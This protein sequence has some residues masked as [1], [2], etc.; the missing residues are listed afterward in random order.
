MLDD[1][2]S[3]WNT[4]WHSYHRLGGLTTY[5]VPLQANLFISESGLVSSNVE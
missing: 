3:D 1:R 4:D 2:H 5:Y